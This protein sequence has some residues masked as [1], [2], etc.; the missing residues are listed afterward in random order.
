M[1]RFPRRLVVTL[2]A[3]CAV[4]GAWPA[5]PAH[6]ETTE[7]AA[8]HVL[9]A[10]RGADRPGPNVTRTKAEALALAQKVV[11]E[12]AAGATIA[13]LAKTYSDDAGSASAGGFLGFFERGTMVAPF[14]AAVEALEP[15]AVS[16]VVESQFGFHVIQRLD[17][18]VAN[19]IMRATRA[20]IVLAFFPWKGVAQDPTVS[21]TKEKAK[22]DAEAAA[23][24]LR[25]GSPMA[26]LPAALGA[27]PAAP[28][29]QPQVISR[30]GIRP[31]FSML[32]A[33]AFALSLGGVSDAVETPVGYAVLQRRPWY[34]MRVQHLVVLYKG[35]AASNPSVT[36]SKEE[37]RARA[38]E[39]LTKYEA[40]PS[41]WQKVVAE[42]SEE[43]DAGARAGSL[44]VAE[45][46][47]FVL[48]FED[49]I[50]NLAAGEHTKVFET[51]F[52]FHVAR[53]V[54]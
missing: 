22:A 11:A 31:E 54:P 39:A 33:A 28:G 47:K 4:L 5:T 15:G 49:A 13:D 19:D 17:E 9:I 24:A 43:P 38:S 1:D 51:P 35:S 42:Y 48:A 16:G 34:R 40:D 12:V 25:S 8:R 45:P 27:S 44:G 29:F 36:R 3:A 50:A 53:R 7:W 21:R 26:T 18:A 41:T 52:G 14:Q 46:G 32:E 37:A 10:Y 20:T 2:L 6:A 30:G 23:A